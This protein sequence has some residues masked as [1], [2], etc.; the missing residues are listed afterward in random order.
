MNDFIPKKIAPQA[1]SQKSQGYLPDEGLQKAVKVA[2]ALGQPLLLTGEPGCGKTQAAYWL[3]KALKGQ[4]H[5]NSDQ[6]LVFNAKTSSVATDLLYTYDALAHF[7]AAHLKEPH[8]DL[9]A[10][11]FITLNA[12]GQAIALTNPTDRTRA[13]WPKNKTLV[14]GSHVV[15]IDEIDKAPRDFPNDLLDVMERFAF[16]IKET[17]E[18]LKKDPEKPVVVVLTSNSEKG[19]PDAFLR[20]CIFYHLPFPEKPDLQEIAKVHF[21]EKVPPALLDYFLALREKARLKKPST[22]E[23]LGWLEALRLEELWGGAAA[24]LEKELLAPYLG[25]LLKNQDDLARAKRS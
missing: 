8:K 23:L 17:N 24:T 5:F 11:D 2:L 18:T 21:N 12:L 4:P 19:L 9:A 13:Y 15:L 1:F 6:P 22:S 10:R 14:Q 20:R 7:H 16:D 25:V 3:A